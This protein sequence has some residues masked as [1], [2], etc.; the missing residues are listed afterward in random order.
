MFLGRY[1]FDGDPA[2]LTDAYDRF[3]AQVPDE[4]IGWHVC[5]TH[6]AGLTI[7]DTCPSREVF[8]SFST[9]PEVIGAMTSAGL[10]RPTVTPLGEVH[11]AQSQPATTG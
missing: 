3:L 5:I 10:P 7:Y 6:A 2:P 8:E 4:A 9:N 11:H 1:E